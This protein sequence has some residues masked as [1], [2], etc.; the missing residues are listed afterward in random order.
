MYHFLNFWSSISADLRRGER[1]VENVGGVFL[2]QGR[3]LV[4]DHASSL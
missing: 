1:F 4:P 3:S 2:G